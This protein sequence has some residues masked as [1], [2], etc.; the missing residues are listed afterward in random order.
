MRRCHSTPSSALPRS[1]SQHEPKHALFVK[2][3]AHRP[4]VSCNLPRSRQSTEVSAAPV[5]SSQRSPPPPHTA[6]NP[7]RKPRQAVFSSRT[8]PPAHQ[9]GSKPND[10]H[11]GRKR[12]VEAEPG[13]RPRQ[14]DNALESSAKGLQMV[15]PTAQYG[16]PR[17]SPLPCYRTSSPPPGRI[18]AARLSPSQLPILLPLPPPSPPGHVRPSAV[19]QCAAR[20]EQ[21]HADGLPR[22]RRF[23]RKVLANDAARWTGSKYRRRPT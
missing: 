2:D 10:G 9:G 15:T 20:P 16:R 1:T 21:R 17:R 12:P 8:A 6:L 23:G 11:R 7:R 14:S 4:T 18:D 3:P 5:P 13:S 22:A 19:L